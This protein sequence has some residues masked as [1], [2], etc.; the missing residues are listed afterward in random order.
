MTSDCSTRGEAP[1]TT[2]R[3]TSGRRMV[4][5]HV[6]K[7]A[8]S[9][10]SLRLVADDNS[11]LPPWQ[12]GAHVD[13]LLP[14]GRVRQ[15]SLCG[16]PRDRRSYLVAV[17]LEHGGRGGSREVIQNAITGDCFNVRGPRNNFELVPAPEYLFIAGGIGITPIAAMV[18]DAARRHAGWHLHYGG[19]RRASMAFV[20]DLVRIGGERV[21]ICPED[22]RGQLDLP[23]ILATANSTTDIYCCGPDGL[24]RA[25]EDLIVERPTGGSLHVERFSRS[26]TPVA[27]ESEGDAPRAFE[28][29]LRRTGVVLPVPADRSILEV[30][31]EVST[32]VISSCEEGYCGTCETRV[33]GG[34]PMHRDTVLTTEERARGDRMMICVSRS[35]SPRLVLDL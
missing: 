28:V 2:V 1:A 21:S 9:V 31:A 26:A 11:E 24:L 7:E 18:R 22:E 20:E 35:E 17:Q 10:L 23:A 3:D 29:E 5:S 6:A 34:V 13:F 12:P 25:V 15:Y 16:D 19:R 30:V 32:E 14:S 27:S 8:E 33:L 4:V